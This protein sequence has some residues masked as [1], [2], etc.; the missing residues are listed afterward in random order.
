MKI[1]K[2][3]KKMFTIYSTSPKKEFMPMRPT[4]TKVM[5]G[6]LQRFFKGNRFPPH[7]SDLRCSITHQSHDQR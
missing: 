3:K 7:S 1:K 6:T 4:E 2:K 5:I